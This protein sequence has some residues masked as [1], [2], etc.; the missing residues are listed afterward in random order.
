M[1][2]PKGEF[3]GS[4]YRKSGNLQSLKKE[5]ISE[6]NERL[7]FLNIYE[8][9]IEKYR[10]AFQIPPGISGIPTTWNGDVCAREHKSLAP[11]S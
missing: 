5:K 9:T 7:T 1:A 11:G 4:D 3:K 10:M 6:I 2:L 8:L